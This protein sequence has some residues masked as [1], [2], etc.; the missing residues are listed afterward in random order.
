MDPHSFFAVPLN[1]DPDPEADNKRIR[2]QPYT[3]ILYINEYPIEYFN[4]DPNLATAYTVLFPCC[5]RTRFNENDVKMN[6]DPD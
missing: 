6:E 3:C 4:A 2:I 5:V 1:A